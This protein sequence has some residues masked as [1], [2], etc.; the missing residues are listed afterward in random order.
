MLD[1]IADLMNEVEKFKGTVVSSEELRKQLQET[2]TDLTRLQSMQEKLREDY[3]TYI[4][5]ADKW[6]KDL[7][8]NTAGTLQLIQ[9]QSQ[10]MSR[11][12]TKKS[13][14]LSEDVERKVSRITSSFDTKFKEQTEVLEGRINSLSTNL[15]MT[16]NNIVTLSK[17][18]EEIKTKTKSL[19]GICIGIGVV[20]IIIL[21]LCLIK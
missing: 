5:S 17:E 21:L 9:N 19:Y 4:E 20:N 7:E 14:E 12:L 15:A 2:V 11:E 16:S 3:E 1:N 13:D 10:E 8:K 18:V 6:Q